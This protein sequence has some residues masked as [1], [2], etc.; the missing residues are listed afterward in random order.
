MIKCDCCNNT[1]DILIEG[2]HLCGDC[3]NYIYNGSCKG[4]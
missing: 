1:F 3:Y 4:V 2:E